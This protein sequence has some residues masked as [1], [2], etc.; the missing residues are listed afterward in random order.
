MAK[1]PCAGPWAG[2]KVY[3]VWLATPG[4]VRSCGGPVRTWLEG[5]GM[6]EALE[7]VRKESGGTTYCVAKLRRRSDYRCFRYG[8]WLQGRKVRFLYAGNPKRK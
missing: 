8:P 6:P 2:S 3:D 7:I 4:K 5:H 1:D